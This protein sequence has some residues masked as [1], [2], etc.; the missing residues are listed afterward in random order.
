MSIFSEYYNNN[1]LA[2]SISSV[3]KNKILELVGDIKSK[4]VL[5]VGCTSGYLGGGL[6]KEVLIKLLD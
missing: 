4:R 1:E 6:E 5:D 2:Y 3:R